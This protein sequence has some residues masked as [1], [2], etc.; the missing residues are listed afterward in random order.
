[1]FCALGLLSI[2]SILWLLNY[3]FHFFLNIYYRLLLPYKL[4]FKFFNVIPGHYCEM[5]LV[6]E[7]ICAPAL[8]F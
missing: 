6:F 8:E 7:L 2:L 4:M 3:S 5:N 1:M